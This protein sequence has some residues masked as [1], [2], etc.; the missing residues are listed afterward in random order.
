MIKSLNVGAALLLVLF[1][2][3]A[4]AD[5][6]VD[7]FRGDKW[8]SAMASIKG[9]S[10]DP[11]IDFTDSQISNGFNGFFRTSESAAEIPIGEARLN[12]PLKYFFDDHNR[13]YG[14]SGWTHE[15]DLNHHNDPR[16]NS[17][18]AYLVEALTAKFGKPDRIVTLPA[19]ASLVKR[20]DKWQRYFW[21]GKTVIIVH[22]VSK[23]DNGAALLNNGDISLSNKNNI[24]TYADLL[25]LDGETKYAKEFLI[26]I[27]YQPNGL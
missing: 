19:P 27:G 2:T 17:N 11:A 18:G 5:N 12:S 24:L 6:Q 23:T 15:W 25:L 21:V 13:F 10:G 8:G 4:F 22:L 7:G 9:L 20:S 16:D 1:A 26:K 3:V 14:V